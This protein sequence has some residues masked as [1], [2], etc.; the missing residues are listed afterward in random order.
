MRSTQAMPPDTWPAKEVTKVPSEWLE[1]KCQSG[2]A[3]WP[4]FL[5]TLASGTY[6]SFPNFVRSATKF[7]HAIAAIDGHCILLDLL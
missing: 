4:F 3:C 6:E 1:R 5:K 7:Q 2:F